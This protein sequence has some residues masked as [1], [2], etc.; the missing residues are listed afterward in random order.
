MGERRATELYQPVHD[1][2]FFCTCHV[3]H[4]AYLRKYVVRVTGCK[5]FDEIHE[6]EEGLTKIATMMKENYDT[7]VLVYLNELE[8]DR[9][10]L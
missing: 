5:H 9:S 8:R 10:R 6:Q 1:D 7:A 4:L 2:F 3:T